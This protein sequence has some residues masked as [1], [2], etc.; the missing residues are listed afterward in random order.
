MLY[1]YKQ[2]ERKTASTNFNRLC[3]LYFLAAL[4]FHIS[5]LIFYNLFICFVYD[6]I[7]LLSICFRMFCC[8]HS[9]TFDTYLLS[10]RF[11]CVDI[12]YITFRSSEN[13]TVT[14]SS[15]ILILIETLSN[16]R[17]IKCWFILYL[18]VYVLG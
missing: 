8:K 17:A 4:Y 5:T 18:Q 10:C 1:W 16:F 9:I 2:A 7:F 3:F 6:S 15:A 13:F 11:H 12:F 14:N